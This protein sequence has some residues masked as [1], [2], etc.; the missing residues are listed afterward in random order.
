[1]KTIFNPILKRGFQKVNDAIQ[2]TWSEITGKP[3]TFP[4]EPHTHNSIESLDST[5]KVEAT[6]TEVIVTGNLNVSG[7]INQS[8]ALYETNV[9]KINSAQQLIDLRSGAV[10]GMSTE[11]YAGFKVL[12]YDGVNNLFFAVDNTGTARIGDEGGELQ[13][14][15]TREENPVNGYFATWDSTTKKL[16]FIPNPS[17]NKLYAAKWNTFLGDEEQVILKHS[18]FA[19]SAGG[20]MTIQGTSGSTVINIHVFIFINHSGSSKALLHVF[21]GDYS[22]LILKVY[23][24]NTGSFELSIQKQI[25]Y[26]LTFLNLEYRSFYDSNYIVYNSNTA[27]TMELKESF[28]TQP[29]ATIY[30]Y[31]NFFKDIEIGG[32][33]TKNG[34]E[35]H[36]VSLSATEPTSPADGDI[37]IIP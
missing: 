9:E 29:G 4:A 1:M 31:K 20:E 13:A 36:K 14:L 2:T 24:D 19:L 18:N 15:A 33:I 5:K 11:E 21:S 16:L 37:W 32:M 7:I 10:A 22:Q 30:S 25:S 35:F 8:G 34:S 28:Y 12:K 23:S 17:T 3:D 27:P 6:N 26:D